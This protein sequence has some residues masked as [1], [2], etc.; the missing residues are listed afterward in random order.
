MVIHEVRFILAEKS[1]NRETS[2]AMNL[3]YTDFS[4]MQ[5]LYIYTLDVTLTLRVT[6]TAGR[7]V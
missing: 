3:Q 1:G 7:A 4:T 2:A 6:L 5:Q